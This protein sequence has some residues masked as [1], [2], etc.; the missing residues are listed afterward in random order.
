MNNYKYYY[1]N[2]KEHGLVRNN[3]IYTSLIDDSQTTFVQWYYND[4]EYHKNLNEV[5][6]P[7]LMEMK[8]KREVEFLTLMVK[9]YPEHVPEVLHIDNKE[10]KIYLKIDGPDFWQQSLDRNISFDELL[11]DWQDQMIE[12]ICCH[13][14]L[15]FYK[16]SNHP[17]SYFLIDGKLKCINYFFCYWFNEEPRTIRE[18]LSHI[19]HNRQEKIASDLAGTGITVDT[20]LTLKKFYDMS[21]W[22][23]R[24]NYPEDFVLRASSIY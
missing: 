11:P 20:P 9:N 1:N 16:I 7:E 2:T 19:S 3:L 12:I 18:H 4:T 24:S 10:R 15:G 6:D 5:V 13:K 8:W 17:S 23:F 22:S 21:Y 14:K